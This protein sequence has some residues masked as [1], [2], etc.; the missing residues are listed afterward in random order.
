[1]VSLHDPEYAAW[2]GRFPDNPAARAVIIVD[3]TRVSTSC[4][5]A[6]PILEPV[7]ERD[8]LTEKMSRRGADGIAEY[9]RQ[10]NAMSID[11]LPAV[12]D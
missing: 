9:R 10:H 2:A 5:Y 1:M 12:D 6:L 4:G 8:L 3:V 7:S 11:G